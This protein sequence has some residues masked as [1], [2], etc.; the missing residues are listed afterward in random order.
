MRRGLIK[1]GRPPS[2][3]IEEIA[4]ILARG[5]GRDQRKQESPPP[6]LDQFP[7]SPLSV[8][9]RGLGAADDGDAR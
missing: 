5:I 9:T 2:D 3:S 1:S 6:C 4:A 8:G 7:P